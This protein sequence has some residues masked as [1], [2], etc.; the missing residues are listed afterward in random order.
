[1]RHTFKRTLLPLALIAVFAYVAVAYVIASSLTKSE[2]NDLFNTPADYGLSF[3]E[4]EFPSR[5]GDI[6]L[7]GWIIP[8]DSGLE[9][10]GA[11]AVVLVHGINS[12]R[13]G[14][15]GQ[16]TL[17]ASMLV[18]AG[19]NVL[20]FDLRGH[21]ISGGDQISGGYIERLDV[22]G[23]VDVLRDRGLSL[24]SIGLLG[25]SMGAATALLAA[26]GEP[27][28]GALVVDSPYADVSDLMAQETARATPLP[29]W[30]APV[31]IPMTKL[32]AG[33]L[34]DIDV[35]AMVPDVAVESLN[36]PILVV[37]GTTDDRIPTEQGKRVHAAAHPDS[38][39]WLVEGVDHTEAF[40][41][42][43]DIYVERVTA[44]FA[45]RLQ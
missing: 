8:A 36:Y 7:S 33:V 4:I 18:Q 13:T 44:Y 31:F 37:H 11:Q 43:P 45:E 14:S 6:T 25:F 17:L 29:E 1:M 20:M 41:T 28:V 26:A 38:E 24:D 27:G 5:L 39:L 23:A 19:Y 40:D 30:A 15:D 12:T 42:Y 9:V 2:R 16:T 22:L 32:I 35:G 10:E 3:Q 34:Y 21:G